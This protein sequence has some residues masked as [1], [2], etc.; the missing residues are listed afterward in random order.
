MKNTKPLIIS[1]TGAS[2]F[3]ACDFC[4][5][6]LAT[7]QRGQVTHQFSAMELNLWLGSTTWTSIPS[8]KLSDGLTMS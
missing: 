7:K 5:L 6:A 1:R 2:I 4:E 3:M 8:F